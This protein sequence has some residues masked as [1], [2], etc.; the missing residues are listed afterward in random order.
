[1]KYV[2]YKTQIF[3]IDPDKSNESFDFL[4]VYILEMMPDS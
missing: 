2:R 1:M 4:G 3:L